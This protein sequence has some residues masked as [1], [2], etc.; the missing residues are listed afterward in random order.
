[1]AAG[2][3]AI[4]GWKYAP[5]IGVGD[6]ISIEGVYAINPPRYDVMYGWGTL[7]PDFAVRILD[8]E[9]QRLKPSEYTFNPARL[10][11]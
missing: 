7:R 6:T 4:V 3:A 8:D 9:R 5:A 11:L 1:M 2:L 10:P